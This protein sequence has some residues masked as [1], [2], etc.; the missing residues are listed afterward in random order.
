MLLFYLGLATAS[1]L[2]IKSVVALERTVQQH[3]LAADGYIELGMFQEA[4]AQLEEIDPFCRSAPEVLTARVAIYHG[5]KKWDLMAVVDGKLVEW[6]PNE[7]E[8]FIE[9]AY[10]T[11]RAESIEAARTIL[12]RAAGLHPNEGTI[13]F[14]LACLKRKWAICTERKLT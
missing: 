13:Q 4:N 2:V 1:G 14:N 12:E 5:L 6:N 8:H 7:P 3:L 9:L 11:R 10:A